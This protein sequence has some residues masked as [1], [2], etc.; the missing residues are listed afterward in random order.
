[1]ELV[2]NI[3]FYLSWLGAGLS[4]W[5]MGNKESI[6]AWNKPVLLLSISVLAGAT[7][8]VLGKPFW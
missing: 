5:L 7:G 8:A 6:I 1:M 2:G 4:I 3:M